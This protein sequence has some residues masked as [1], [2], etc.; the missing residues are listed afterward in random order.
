MQK[1]LLVEDDKFLRNIYIQMLSSLYEVDTAED[2]ET[3]Y[4]DITKNSYDLI[5]LDMFLPKLDGKQ[6]YAQLEKNFPNR[7]K[8]KVVFMTNDDSQQTVSYFNTL[9]IKYLI[10]S[11]FN[12][13]EFV[14]K[15]KSYLI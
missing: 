7:F 3:A 6:V 2:G 5:L 10:K 11:T 13:G 8:N 4:E 12:P 1:I 9:G 15:I 14:N